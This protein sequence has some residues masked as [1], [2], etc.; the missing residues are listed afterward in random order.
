MVMTLTS[1]L[2][3][4]CPWNVQDKTLLSRSSATTTL[5][6]RIINY[7]Y[8]SLTRANSGSASAVELMTEGRHAVKWQDKVARL[9]IFTGPWTAGSPHIVD[10]LW[11]S[12]EFH[13]TMNKRFLKHGC[14]I[15]FV[16]IEN[17]KHKI[18]AITH[19]HSHLTLPLEFCTVLKLHLY[20]V[21]IR[22]Q[23]HW[24]ICWPT[25]PFGTFFLSLRPSQICLFAVWYF[26]AWKWQTL[27][28][29]VEAVGVRNFY[30]HCSDCHSSLITKAAGM[31]KLALLRVCVCV[32]VCVS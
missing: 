19:T 6:G 31:H 7:L 11:W 3:F 21:L 24:L 29:W 10:H 8:C 28:V 2:F 12:S 15:Y 14:L 13:W 17:N 1:T 26:P 4:L 22:H 20:S 30:L 18:M 9:K 5:S 25:F 23:F 32:Y 16:E 27:W